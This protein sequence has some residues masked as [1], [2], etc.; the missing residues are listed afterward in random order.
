MPY[1]KLCCKQF[2][3]HEAW[4]GVASVDLAELVVNSSITRKLSSLA[5]NPQGD[6]GMVSQPLARWSQAKLKIA[7]VTT[8]SSF[9]SR[10]GVISEIASIARANQ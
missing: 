10:D 3:S 7:Y 9:E 1:E 8:S 5:S 2:D 6:L 4:W